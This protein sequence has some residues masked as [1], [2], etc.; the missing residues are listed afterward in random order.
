MSCFYEIL[1]LYCYFLIDL[2][3]KLI[4]NKGELP[5][6]WKESIVKLIHR[7]GDKTDCSNYG[8]ISLLSTSYKILFNILFCRLTPNADEIIR[9]HECGFG[10]NK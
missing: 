2:N 1:T 3:V 10:C 5:Q 7:K 4:W 6:Q 8:S 9:D